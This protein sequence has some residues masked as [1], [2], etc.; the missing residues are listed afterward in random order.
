M[1]GDP[2]LDDKV[3]VKFLWITRPMYKQLVLS[4]ETLLDVFTLSIEEV[5]GRL[6]TA[7]EDVGGSSV[8]EGKLLLTEEEW[9]EKS[10]KK[11]A[12][13][14]SRGGS[15]GGRGWGGYDRDSGNC[16]RGDGDSSS[17]G[18]HCSKL[19]NW[20]RECHNKQPKKEE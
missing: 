18:H 7:E 20:A 8:V 19:G 6:K 13:D 17:G 4:I 5:T 14:G 11:K 16:G 3:M 12:K 9:V 15:S 2:E 10:K 1:L